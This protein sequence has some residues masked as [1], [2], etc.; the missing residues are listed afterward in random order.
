MPNPDTCVSAILRS[1]TVEKKQYFFSFLF[2]NSELDNVGDILF[3]ILWN[4]SNKKEQY[5][6]DSVES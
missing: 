1:F 3:K 4:H 2:N 6:I 5:G